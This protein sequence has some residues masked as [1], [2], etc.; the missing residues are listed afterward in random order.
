M[1]SPTSGSAAPP[2][3]DKTV[4]AS[5][6]QAAMLGHQL[7]L[8]YQ[9][10]INLQN[11]HICGFETLMRWN[12]PARGV[13][14]PGVFIPVAEESGLI[15]Q[16]SK[17]ALKEAIRALKRLEGH[18]GHNEKIYMSV[19]FSPNDLASETF[20]DE[21][22]YI[23]SASDVR[24]VQVQLEIT[25]ELLKAQPEQALETLGICRSTGLKVAV[26][27]Y[28]LG[29]PSVF[30]GY[31]D[32]FPLSAVKIDQLII[33]D[34]LKDPVK[35]D[36]VKKIIEEAKKRNIEV[37]AEGVETK[38]E[39]LELLRLGCDYGQGYYF[40]K[41]LP[42]RELTGLLLQLTGFLDRLKA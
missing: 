35:I 29:D 15:V 4:L 22:Y 21:M 34:L 11:G 20:V 18:V 13:I 10:I 28:G 30:M 42:E 39:A 5:E 2:P 14:S 12:H 31:M 19:N 36:T 9:P 3:I 41:P 26:D 40:M 38:E 32:E 16:A 6:F 8:N 1:T 17:W 37:I 23:I 24:P 27:D 25:G 7:T 33:R